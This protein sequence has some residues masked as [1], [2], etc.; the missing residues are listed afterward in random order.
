MIEIYLS[1]DYNKDLLKVEL[2]WIRETASRDLTYD[3]NRSKGLDVYISTYYRYTKKDVEKWSS[4][5][6]F[7][8]DILIFIS[9][10]DVHKYCNGKSIGYSTVYRYI[11]EM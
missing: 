11:E 5:I 3:V 4:L 2:R 1:E 8:D 10:T 6:S 7:K 9:D